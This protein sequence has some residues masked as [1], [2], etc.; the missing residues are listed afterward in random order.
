METLTHLP[1]SI[2]ADHAAGLALIQQRIGDHKDDT[3][4]IEISRDQAVQ[5]ADFLLKSFRV[6]KSEA[7]QGNADGFE[8][9]WAAY[10]SKEAKQTA[11]SIWK[12]DNCAALLDQILADVERR[13]NSKQWIDGYVPHPT[14][15]LRQKRYLDDPAE[16]N[17]ATPWD[18]AL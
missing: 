11:L 4:T 18:D 13:K 16:S 14:T 12:R 9:F 7:V 10:P 15:Y 5:I 1:I 17:Q 3:I 6:K 2:E 8:K